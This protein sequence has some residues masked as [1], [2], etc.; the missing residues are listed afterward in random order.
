MKCLVI[1]RSVFL[2][3]VAAIS[4]YYYLLL[5]INTSARILFVQQ[6]RQYEHHTNDVN[7]EASI[8]ARQ[9]RTYMAGLR[10]W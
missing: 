1:V 9:A 8:Q 6:I 10:V 4:T 7:N 3:V 2:P 5:F